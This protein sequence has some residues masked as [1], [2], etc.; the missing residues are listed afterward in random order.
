MLQVKACELVKLYIQ[1]NSRFVC[2]CGKDLNNL[3][4]LAFT[5]NAHKY[6]NRTQQ[7]HGDRDVTKTD[8]PDK[9][10]LLWAY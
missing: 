9:I 4:Y 8:S 7:D 5:I 10:A 6:I 2:L 3:S 1:D